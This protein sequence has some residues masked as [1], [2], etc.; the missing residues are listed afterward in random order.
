MSDTEKLLPCPFCG[1]K[2]ELLMVDDG[3]YLIYAQC[4]ECHA[5]TTAGVASLKNPEEAL[6]SIERCKKLIIEEWNKRV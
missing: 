1:G 4:K 5:R 3:F 6:E 2:A